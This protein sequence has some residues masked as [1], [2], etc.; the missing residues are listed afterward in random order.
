MIGKHLSVR[1]AA[2]ALVVLALVIGV[3]ACGGESENEKAHKDQAT[4]RQA[5]FARL[6]HQE[7]IDQA[8]FSPTR[9]TI[10]FW[11]KTWGHDPNKLSYVY[12]Q[13]DNGQLTGYYIFRG[14]PV[15]ECA[16]LTENYEFVDPKGDDEKTLY[17][18]PAPG[19]DGVYYSGG[20]C[21]VYYGEDA[22]THSFME[23]S[24]SGGQSFQLY[25]KPLPRQHVEPLGF[26]TIEDV[27]E[28]GDE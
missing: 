11:T 26:T 6:S 1:A 14:L 5:E 12:M 15:T 10:N 18:V 25:E 20:Q 8:T 4:T 7:K 2:A 24:L 3:S 16:A 21:D 13:A 23:F 19:V 27:K 17:Q 22:L 9:R 28:K